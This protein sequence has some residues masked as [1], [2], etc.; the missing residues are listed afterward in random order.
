MGETLACACTDGNDTAEGER[1]DVRESGVTAGALLE[2][3]ENGT[4]FTSREVS[5][6]LVPSQLPERWPNTWGQMQVIQVVGVF[7]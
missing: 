2:G 7:I 5:L 3:R 4:Q 1:D 6:D